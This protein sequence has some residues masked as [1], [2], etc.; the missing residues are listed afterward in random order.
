VT[1]TWM[2]ATTLSAADLSTT[3]LVHRGHQRWDIENYA[4]NELGKY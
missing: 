1:T 3:R 2:W 4:F